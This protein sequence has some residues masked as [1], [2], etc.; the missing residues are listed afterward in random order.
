V[1]FELAP[2]AL[3]APTAVAAL[4]RIVEAVAAD[5]EVALTRVALRGRVLE[6]VGDDR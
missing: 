3:A 5:M 2:S 4:A 1:S 6:R